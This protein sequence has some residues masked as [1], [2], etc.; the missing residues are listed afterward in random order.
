[1]S[2]D[3]P[4]A[5]R[6][7]CSLAAA[8]GRNTIGCGRRCAR[9]ARSL[10]RL[11][12]SSVGAIAPLHRTDRFDE[13]E[14]AWRT[15]R[16]RDIIGFR[17]V[18]RCASRMFAALGSN[19][20]S[21]LRVERSRRQRPHGWLHTA[22][23]AA[24]AAAITATRGLLPEALGHGRELLA[25]L[26]PRSPRSRWRTACGRCSWHRSSPTTRRAH[27][28]ERCRTTA[29]AAARAG[30]P[31]YGVRATR[32]G[33]KRAD[34]WGG[35]SPRCVRLDRAADVASLRRTCSMLGVARLHRQRL[36]AGRPVLTARGPTASRSH[37]AALRRRSIS[38]SSSS[39]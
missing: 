14:S 17:L 20:P 8:P 3:E 22:V 25:V 4:D 24:L 39:T 16:V 28:G 34:R 7:S 33:P 21:R 37:R 32:R 36:L 38:T 18:R 9:Q 30:R 31:I 1:M 27:P 2:P 10:R 5:P 23:C 15:L 29:C 19:S 11:A 6:S 13:A 12:D 26:P 35:W